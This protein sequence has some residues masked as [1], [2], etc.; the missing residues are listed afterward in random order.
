MP[1]NE[2]V[3][4]AP[5]WRQRL[6]A[7]LAA[8]V[9]L[10]LVAALCLAGAWIGQR[11]HQRY[12][13]QYREH[14]AQVSRMVARAL[15]E[16]M[17]AGGGAGVWR[18]VTEVSREFQAA[19][20]AKRILV[21]ARDGRVKSTTDASLEGHRFSRETDPECA[22]CHGAGMKRFP[23]AVVRAGDGGRL[24]RV[25]GAIEK[26][27]GCEGC[28][29]EPEAFRGMIA[30]DFDLSGIE[31]AARDRERL[32]AGIGV[33]AALSMAGFIIALLR[34]LVHRPIGDLA[35]SARALGE[36]NLHSRIA[37]RRDDELGRLA[38]EFNRMA[39]RIREQVDHIESG[40][41]EMELLYNL[42]VEVSRNMEVTQVRSAVLK[43]MGERLPYRQLLF[44]VAAGERGWSTQVR[45]VSGRDESFSGAGDLSRIVAGDDA[46][47]EAAL[48]GI[49]AALVREA[50]GERRVV[51]SR[52]G[53]SDH[54]VLPLEHRGRLAGIVVASHGAP[55]QVPDEALLRNLAVH[56]GL[57]LDNALNFTQSITD[58]LT[59]LANKRHGLVRLEEALYLARRHGVPVSLMMVDVDYFKKVN[60]VH[61]H[62]AGDAVLKGVAARLRADSRIG[63]IVARYGGEEFMVILPHTPAAALED[64]AERMRQAVQ[65]QPVALPDGVT[66]ITVTA[67]VGAAQCEADTDTPASLIA[68]ADEALY[69]AKRAGRNRVVVA[70]GRRQS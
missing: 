21:L 64:L 36:G 66:S 39:G 53:G 20:G 65:A 15:S 40:R 44:C 7:R 31:A 28:H 22:E 62:L 10:V 58:G 8:G 60:D 69:A 68:R 2:E 30:I 34:A 59:G 37:V 16:R 29:R 46:A 42:V 19:V 25:V 61:G 54:L 70:P 3:L 6:S 18:D 38:G 14:A 67:S 1:G 47:I 26:R 12:E 23:S 11:E 13:S 48:P 27:P 33:V 50:C 9:V 57:A 24:L 32:L 56:I 43:V 49:P 55:A 52:D 45:D 63:D 5:P 41:R 4:A 51:L 17:L 35:R